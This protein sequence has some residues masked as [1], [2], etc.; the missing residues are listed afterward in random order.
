MQHWMLCVRHHQTRSSWRCVSGTSRGTLQTFRIH[1]GKTQ[2]WNATG[3]LR[4]K[5]RAR[6]W[7]G[8]NIPTAEQ[9]VRVLGT[10]LGHVDYVQTQLTQKLV[11]HDVLFQAH[12][13]C[14]NRGKSRTECGHVTNVGLSCACSPPLL[15]C[16][17]FRATIL[18]SLG[19]R[20]PPAR[21]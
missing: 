21:T 6:V 14:C 20:S 16:R 15:W 18:G 8:S 9:G 13:G 2:V 11:E 10:P 17:R 3:D 5:I 12:R 4:R 7:K 1:A 19:S